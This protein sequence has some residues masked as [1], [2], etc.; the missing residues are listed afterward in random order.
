MTRV[1]Y[2]AE[3]KQNLDG[4]FDY[5]AR[6]NRSPAAAAKVLRDIDQK[7]RLYSRFPLA[8]QSREDLAPGVRCFPVDNFV[9]IYHP[10]EDGIL[11]LLV[12]HGHQDIPSALRDLLWS[13]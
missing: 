2:T 8:S 11:I 9:V 7:C 1:I 6:Q 12:L 13:P 4:I 3:A 10:N 5:I